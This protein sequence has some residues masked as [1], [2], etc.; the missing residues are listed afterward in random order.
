MSQQK[1]SGFGGLKQLFQFCLALVAT[2]L[3]INASGIH[4]W[5]QRLEIGNEYVPRQALVELTGSWE[6][7]IDATGLNELRRS[8]MAYRDARNE[9][10]TSLEKS[11]AQISSSTEITQSQSK[12]SDPKIQNQTANEVK[13]N[14]DVASK[15]LEG[16]PVSDSQ[17]PSAIAGASS[18][19]YIALVGDS[20]MAVG[21]A[22]NLTRMIEK[23]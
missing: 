22:P 18:E 21:L 13:S 8:V 6:K 23:N 2:A 15:V 7:I 16:K 10:K 19:T 11:T 4:Q 5:A 14:E 3:L 9:G 17:I 12:D 1:S 20:M